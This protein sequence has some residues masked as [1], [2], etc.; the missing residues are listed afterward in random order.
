[1]TAAT[2]PS[3]RAIINQPTTPFYPPSAGRRFDVILAKPGSGSADTKGM[4][5][6]PPPLHGP[7][8]R[9]DAGAARAGPDRPADLRAL[10]PQARALRS[11][12]SRSVAAATSRS[13]LGSRATISPVREILPELDRWRSR[14]DRV[15]MA[16]VVATRRSAPRPDR[17]EADRL[18]AGRARR[19]GLRRLRRE[20][21]RRGSAGRCWPAAS[22]G[23]S[24][25]G[26]RTTS[27]SASGLPCGGE[28][29]VWVDEPAPELLDQLGRDRPRGAS[30][31]RPHRP[32]GGNRHG[33]SADGEDPVADEL[34]RAGHGRVV[35]LERPARLRGRL[36]AATATARLRRGRHCGCALRGRTRSRLAHDRRGRTRAL[37]H[38]GAPAEC[39]RG[40]RRLA[41]GDARAGAAGPRDRD[42]RPH[43]RRQVRRSDARRRAHD[44][45]LLRRSARLPPQSGA[46]SRAAAR[47]RRRRV[48]ARTDQRPGRS[49][50]RRA[51]PCGDCA[52]DPR[53]DHGRPRRARRRHGS[54]S[55][56]AAFTPKSA[57]RV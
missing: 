22:P 41:G 43:P 53:R 57:E 40:D 3:S 4:S 21:S 30:G 38:P 23:C 39:A 14:G 15:A 47:G 2:V 7:L 28:I 52:L 37:R 32:R 13:T 42:R 51:Q 24:P 54:R 36:R 50:H 27:H 18:G 44:R 10:R 35:E 11:S 20:R 16:R 9:T 19:L 29:D 45:R 5:A 55:R 17:L 56:A 48:G 26:S 49:R 46:A 33:S 25:S 1:M 8:G 6:A 34:I 31:G 12:A